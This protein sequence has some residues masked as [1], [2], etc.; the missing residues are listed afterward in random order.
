[1]LDNSGKSAGERFEFGKNWARF[2]GKLQGEQI[3]AQSSH[4][5][6]CLELITYRHEAFLTRGAEADFLAWLRGG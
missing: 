3:D 4:S 2:L 5:K 1:M 6:K